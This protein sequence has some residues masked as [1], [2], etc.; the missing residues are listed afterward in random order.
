MDRWRDLP[1]KLQISQKNYDL[2]GVQDA[3]PVNLNWRKID[4]PL[5]VI[6]DENKRD[7]G[8]AKLTPRAGLCSIYH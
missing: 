7:V 1:H 4:Y 8:F 5:F 2:A 3:L 6:V